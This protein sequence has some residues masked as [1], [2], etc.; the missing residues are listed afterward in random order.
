MIAE[1]L[2]KERRVVVVVVAA[3][4]GVAHAMHRLCS[5]ERA[6]HCFFEKSSW[7]FLNAH[8]PH[9]FVGGGGGGGPGKFCHSKTKPAS[10]TKANMTTPDTN[11]SSTI[12]NEASTCACSLWGYSTATLA[13]KPVLIVRRPARRR[14]RLE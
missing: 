11:S 2:I 10:K 4:T 13:G 5:S 8:P 6:F 12:V 1:N 14:R 9:N 7:F 3:V